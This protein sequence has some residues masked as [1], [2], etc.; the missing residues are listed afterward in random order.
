MTKSNSEARKQIEAG[1]VSVNDV[2]ITDVNAALT[3]DQFG[4]EGVLLRKG[5][6]S[7]YRVVLRG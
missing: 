6:K 7:Y 1:A 3:D 4:D 2:K 5:K